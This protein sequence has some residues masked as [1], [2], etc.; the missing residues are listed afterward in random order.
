MQSHQCNRQLALGTRKLHIS[1]LMC[2]SAELSSRQKCHLWNWQ[3]KWQRCFVPIET[4]KGWFDKRLVWQRSHKQRAK[5]SV[6]LDNQNLMGNESCST[7]DQNEDLT[8]GNCLLCVLSLSCLYLRVSYGRHIVVQF[9]RVE[10]D[11]GKAVDVGVWLRIPPL[12]QAGEATIANKVY[13]FRLADVHRVLKWEE[14]MT[15][16]KDVLAA[17]TMVE[18]LSAQT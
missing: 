16:Y 12:H 7:E 10:G 6:F 13:G 15:H 8:W 14:H 9:I 3:L 2:H 1:R 5:S 17:A 11:G 4:T 18:I